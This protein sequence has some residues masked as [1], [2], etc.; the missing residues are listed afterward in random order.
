VAL[1]IEQTQMVERWLEQA[2]DCCC[3]SLED[4][5]LFDEKARA[6]ADCATR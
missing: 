5:P 3:P 2:A 4:C 6:L 1:L